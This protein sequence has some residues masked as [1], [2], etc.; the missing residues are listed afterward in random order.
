MKHRRFLPALLCLLT[1]LLSG[2][3]GAATYTYTGGLY[4]AVANFTPPCSAGPCADYST[5]MRVTGWFTTAVPLAT[6]LASQDVTSLVTSYSFSDGIN[7]IASSDPNARIYLPFV[8]STDGSGNI[9]PA[10]SSLSVM[11]WETGTAPHNAAD[12]LSY[13]DPTG[14]SNA[15]NN[16]GCATVGLSIAGT[17]DSCSGIT[18][19]AAMSV[20]DVPAG[21]WVFTN[22]S[23][24][25]S[26]VPTLSEWAVI[27]LSLLLA[28][29]SPFLN[30]KEPE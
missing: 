26:T 11:L 9:V 6:N 4:P 29:G 17:P 12:R 27:L 20:A 15:V 25:P 30:R 3:V 14:G 19:D 21:T 2:S 5:S 10:S 24:N 23:A 8:I 28:V 7:T 16:N 1:G 22:P 13:I 18:G